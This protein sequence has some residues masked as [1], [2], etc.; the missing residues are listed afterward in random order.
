[1]RLMKPAL[2]CVE[3]VAVCRTPELALSSNPAMP[4]S[5]KVLSVP[6]MRCSDFNAYVTPMRS[7]HLD[8]TASGLKMRDN[9]NSNRLTLMPREGTTKSTR[10]VLLFWLCRAVAVMLTGLPG[11]EAL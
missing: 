3:A 1:M 10:P 8:V 5:N 9:G 7:Y 11:M 6:L 2:I 4:S